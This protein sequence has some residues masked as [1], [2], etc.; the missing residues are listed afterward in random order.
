MAVVQAWREAMKAVQTV[1]FIND[2]NL[3]NSM[4]H[5][6][7]MQQVADSGRLAD[8]WKASLRLPDER[9]AQAFAAA[10]AAGSTLRPVWLSH[11]AL[12]PCLPWEQCESVRFTLSTLPMR[13]FTNGHSW[14]NQ[15]AQHAPGAD[16]PIGEPV[17][18]HFT[19]QF[20]DT[21]EYPHGKRQ[22]AREA[23]LWAVDPPHYFTEGVFVR[24]TSPLYGTED[25]LRVAER[26]P[27]WSPQR[28]MHMD[29]PQRAAVRDLLALSIAADGVMIMPKLHC[30]CDR[31]W[32]FL[33]RCRFPIG[34]RDM[35]IPFGCPQD[36]LYDLVRWN[37]KRVRFREHTFLDNPLVPAAV[38]QNV[39]TLR[40]RSA[41]EGAARSAGNITEVWLDEGT[42]LH[43]VKDAVLR[44]NPQVRLI[45]VS[46]VELR[47]LCRWLGSP[48]ANREFNSLVRY[49][50]TDSSRYC[51]NEDY[52]PVG[53]A[54]DWRNPFTAYN[55]TW[56][57]HYPALF[58]ERYPCDDDG[59]GTAIEERTNS[60]TCP[61][62]ML[63]DW[64]TLAD[65]REVGV[66]SR[67]NIEGYG[68]MDS[69]KYGVA[70]KKILA[71][72]PGGRCPY[73]PGDVP[74][75]GPGHDARG[76]WIGIEASASR[77]G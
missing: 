51:P 70:A 16:T 30:F 67:C 3:F 8:D 21:K 37:S 31:Y 75:G 45:E 52:R 24:L 65:G 63:C 28:H 42:P 59:R 72:M 29:A 39:V 73:P 7:G 76:N 33:S 56:G 43:E 53:G 25:V 11:K 50:L 32:N 1:E 49:I 19:F 64:N 17:T 26:F 54:W 13:A 44:A 48:R 4:I 18:V 36:A 35:P 46:L 77:R 27:E 40:V 10:A 22:R 20:G 68:G 34:P 9:V 60:T 41:G 5:G 2:Q 57:F 55:C 61:R 12:R 74:G 58:P 47:R 6:A 66:L 62:Q 71:Q 23:A 14:F 38:Q 69:S 15:D